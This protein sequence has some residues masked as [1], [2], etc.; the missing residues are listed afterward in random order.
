MIFIGVDLVL[1]SRFNDWHKK[2][3]MMLQRI[4]HDSEISYCLENINKSA[5][6]FAVRFA[7]KE[8][9]FKAITQYDPKHKI[10][11]LTLASSC[12]IK[13]DVSGLPLVVIDWQILSNYFS[14]SKKELS[15]QIFLSVSHEKEHA[16]VIAW[17]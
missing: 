7:G 6:R 8:A 11:F 17:F 10:P 2:P 1:V 15:K 4:F 5:E 14:T 16:I 12:F 9:I 13:K 3:V